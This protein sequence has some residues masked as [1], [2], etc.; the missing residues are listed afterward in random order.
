MSKLVEV[1]DPVVI[2]A[3]HERALIP[4]VLLESL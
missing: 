2:S 3:E 1:F 4:C